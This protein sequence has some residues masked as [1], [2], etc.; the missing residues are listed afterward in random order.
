MVKLI[1]VMGVAVIVTLVTA[2]TRLTV[3]VVV[4][5][6]AYKTKVSTAKLRKP[7]INSIKGTIKVKLKMLVLT[8]KDYI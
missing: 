6:H 5:V 8:T 7:K 2:I 3:V 4:T 1:A